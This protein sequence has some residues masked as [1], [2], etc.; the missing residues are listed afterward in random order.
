[1]DSEGGQWLV[2]LGASDNAG[3]NQGTAWTLNQISGTVWGDGAQA[4]VLPIMAQTQRLGYSAAIVWDVNAV[5]VV[6]NSVTPIALTTVCTNGTQSQGTVTPPV[7]GDGTNLAQWFPVGTKGR[8][9]QLQL[10]P[11]T[12]T[13][14]WKL[15]RA[16][17]DVTA[18]DVQSTDA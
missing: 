17:I 13:T 2:M 3:S 15:F 5:R 12:S 8:G 18:A 1:M 9:I 7:S 14:Q 11:T 10:S 16:E 6:T 4:T